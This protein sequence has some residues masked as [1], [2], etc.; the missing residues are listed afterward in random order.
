MQN[1][2]P[3]SNDVSTKKQNKGAREV[4]VHWASPALEG[5][6][7]TRLLHEWVLSKGVSARH[8]STSTS[9]TVGRRDGKACDF[10]LWRVR[11]CGSTIRIVLLYFAFK[12]AGFETQRLLS[13]FSPLQFSGLKL[14]SAEMLRVQ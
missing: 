5:V 1:V 2:G 9:A 8:T 12:S 7:P 13:F 14:S 4:V 3:S 10:I 6:V 11:H